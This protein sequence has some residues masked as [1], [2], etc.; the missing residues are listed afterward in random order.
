MSEALWRS[1]LGNRLACER[2]RVQN[3]VSAQYSTYCYKSGS[4]ML[5]FIFQLIFFVGFY[6]WFISLLSIDK[7]VDKESNNSNK[8]E[9]I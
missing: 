1:R 3:P 5:N 6:S 7:M 4:N 9:N 2:F 8:I